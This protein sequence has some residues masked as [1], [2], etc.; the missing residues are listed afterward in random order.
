MP[1]SAA[2]SRLTAP[3]RKTYLIISFNRRNYSIEQTL[4]AKSLA[5]NQPECGAI[6]ALPTA[7]RQQR[8]DVLGKV[9]GEQ[10]QRLALGA[11]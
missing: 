3:N 6:A 4:A 10:R 5:P 1:A 11:R 7:L 9:G 8:R 2:A